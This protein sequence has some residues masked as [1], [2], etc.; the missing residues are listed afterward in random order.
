MKVNENLH[1]T[2]EDNEKVGR[3]DA[4]KLSTDFFRFVYFLLGTTIL[5]G[6]LIT[7]KLLLEIVWAETPSF[8]L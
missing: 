4:H 2:K 6:A 5:L 3:L 8:I 7:T 1:I